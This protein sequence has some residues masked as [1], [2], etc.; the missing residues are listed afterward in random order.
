MPSFGSSL[1]RR[2]QALHG[3]KPAN[4]PD[5]G[6]PQQGNARRADLRTT[7]EPRPDGLLIWACLSDNAEAEALLSLLPPLRA[8]MGDVTLLTTSS[9]A[10]PKGA[11]LHLET[12]R[13]DPTSVVGFLEHWQPDVVVWRRPEVDLVVF[14]ALAQ[15]GIQIVWLGAAVPQDRGLTQRFK[16]AVLR[17]LVKKIDTI[18]AK[19]G[20]SRREFLRLGVAE[21]KLQVT[22]NLE[23]LSQVPSCDTE[24]R[25][26]IA[27]Q[28][29]G[30]P[31]WLAIGV[32]PAE[33]HTI[34]AAHRTLIRKS[35]RLLLVLI[36]QD[37]GRTADLTQQLE[38]DTWIVSRRSVDTLPH[39]DDQ[40]FIV[41]RTDECGL[42]MHLASVTWIG[43]TFGDG[44]NRNPLCPA[45]LGS[46][47]LYGPEGGRYTA[48]FDRLAQ[49]GAA[50]KVRDSATLTVEVEYLLAPDKAAEMAMAA[51]D[52]TTKGAEI[53][54]HLMGRLL[55]L[56][57]AAESRKGL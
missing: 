13:F 15:K 27:Q 14:D 35:H 32:D 45:A 1:F 6:D 56:L 34:L 47:V 11:D 2:L 23:P 33:E 57:D 29:D 37:P 52:V 24:E 55:D 5:A 41:D 51:W 21:D 30:R 40:L 43:G 22:G 9:G 12:P 7:P 10:V 16:L 36:P 17:D 50:R 19:D 48:S 18:I 25:D 26:R 20:A 53:G 3:K 44:A 8:E 42:W 38:G 54:E 46:V 39:R 31:V 28:L 49:A 4:Q